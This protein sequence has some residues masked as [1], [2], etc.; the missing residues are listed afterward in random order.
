MGAESGGITAVRGIRLDHHVVNGS[1]GGV[2]GI[3]AL[4]DPVVFV[5]ILELHLYIV[6]TSNNLAGDVGY[7]Q[8]IGL[9]YV[10]AR[11]NS[12]QVYWSPS[13]NSHSVARGGASVHVTF[14]VESSA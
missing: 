8:S 13:L 5:L 4:N 2:V 14:K 6:R 3:V 1:R 11:L 12:V 9:Q 10:F 7:L